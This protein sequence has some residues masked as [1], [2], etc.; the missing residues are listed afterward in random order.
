MDQM[1]LQVQQWVN[2]IYSGRVGYTPV[3]EDGITGWSTITA[4]ITAL[5]IEE[6]ITLPNGTF[7][8][9]TAALCP[10]LSINSDSSNLTTKHEIFIIQGALYCKGYNPNGLD[11]GF[12]S[13][14]QSAVMAFQRDAGLSNLDGI[15]TPMIFKALLNMDAFVL[16]SGGDPKVRTVQQN[17]NRDYSNVIGLMPCDGIYSRATNTALIKALQFDEGITAD[18]IWGPTTA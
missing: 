2:N 1:V 12:G 9:T 17:L 11:G 8:P 16:V 10:T 18:G 6:G 14:V 3:T 7:G 5:Q 15:A 13:G 4:L